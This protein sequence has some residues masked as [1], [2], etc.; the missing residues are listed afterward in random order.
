MFSVFIDPTI[1]KNRCRTLGAIYLY[2]TCHLSHVSVKMTSDKNNIINFVKIKV[3]SLQIDFEFSLMIQ[4]STK[5]IKW[6]FTVFW[7]HCKYVEFLS[8]A[9]GF[10]LSVKVFSLPNKHTFCSALL[11]S[12]L[13]ENGF[14]KFL[15]IAR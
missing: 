7:Q 4:Q 15:W 2:Y 11:I 1:Q 14:N 5:I 12:C 13:F 9:V 8:R 6:N 10:C 3:N